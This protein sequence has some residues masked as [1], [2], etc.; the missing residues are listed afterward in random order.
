MIELE[1]NSLN[2]PGLESQPLTPSTA[3]PQTAARPRFKLVER[4][5]MVW[6]AVDLEQL[7]EE[8]HPARAIWALSGQLDLEAFY[9]PIEAVEGV[10]GR[11][12]WDPRLLVSLWVYAYSRG[13]GSA[14]EIARRC[15]W[16]PAFKWLCG[17][18]EINHH[19]LSD[20]RVAHGGALE[21]L[22]VEVLGVLS[23][24]GLVSLERVMHDGTKVKACASGDS[25]RRQ[26]RLREHMEAA[27]QQVKTLN[28]EA[29]QEPS[30]QEAARRRAAR[31]RQERLE[32]ALHELEQVQQ[33]KH[34]DKEKACAR[35]STSDPESRVMKQ[36]D[37]G[38]APSYNVQISTEATH[39]VIV[40]VGVSQSGNDYVE[41]PG[42]VARVKENLGTQP[43]Q[44]VV[45]GGFTCRE[46]IVAM[47]AEGIDLIGSWRQPA[48]G[49][50]GSGA[51]GVAPEFEAGAFRYEGAEDRYRCPAGA[52]MEHQGQRE[53]AGGVRHDYRARASE[54]KAC[55][56]TVLSG[57]GAGP[58]DQPLDRGP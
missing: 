51:S 9:T 31:E 42:A 30:R 23:T 34:T 52:L 2:L 27:R 20:F 41:L 21:E 55:L 44:V 54:C 1:P 5:Q 25:F 53:V 46:N 22:F 8:D 26:E 43:Q 3:K 38:Y 24:E 19:T 47:A 40:G 48:Q 56:F 28:E 35:A 33:A 14:R 7:I 17:G 18:A 13:I 29:S 49:G 16:D 15:R 10:A 32:Q 36:P 11:T 39:K 57:H 12:P 6:Q 37:G 58:L 45:D 50:A 4:S